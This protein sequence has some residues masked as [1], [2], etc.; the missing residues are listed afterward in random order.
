MTIF[1]HMAHML[2][3]SSLPDEAPAKATD[4][5]VLKVNQKSKITESHRTELHDQCEGH[6]GRELEVPS[7]PHDGGDTEQADFHEIHTSLHI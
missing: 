4:A 1:S 6:E 7:P 2:E 3:K 5:A